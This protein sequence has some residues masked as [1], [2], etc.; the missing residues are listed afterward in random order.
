MIEMVVNRDGRKWVGGGWWQRAVM[1]VPKSEDD[2]GIRL[3]PQ[4]TQI[5]LK[6]V[7]WWGWFPARV[8]GPAKTPSGPAAPPPMPRRQAGGSRC[9]VRKCLTT[10]RST[11][12]AL[13]TSQHPRAEDDWLTDCTGRLCTGG[14]G[15]VSDQRITDMG[16]ID[17]YIM[18]EGQILVR[19]CMVYGLCMLCKK[20]LLR[21]PC[22]LHYPPR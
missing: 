19:C 20:V 14:R 11:R 18:T 8:P 1:M 9:N 10:R 2:E 17:R 15:G 22:S 16:L 21:L 5:F 4:R 6:C 13:W 12:A 7:P 3:T